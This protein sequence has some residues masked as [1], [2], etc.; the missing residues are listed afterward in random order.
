MNN[1]CIDLI[2]NM[3]LFSN[4][5]RAVNKIARLLFEMIE[6]EEY[7][8]LLDKETIDN[9][10]EYDEKISYLHKNSYY[11]NIVKQKLLVKKNQPN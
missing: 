8:E 4:T 11:G 1:E 3:Y 2:T 5:E 7:L 6:I 10:I 9:L